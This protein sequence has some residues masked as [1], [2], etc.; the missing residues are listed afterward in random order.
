MTDE[1]EDRKMIFLKNTAVFTG[2]GTEAAF[3][4]KDYTL[5]FTFP[6]NHRAYPVVTDMQVSGFKKLEGKTYVNNRIPGHEFG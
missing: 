4:G 2:T 5:S 3:Y 1:K 6:D